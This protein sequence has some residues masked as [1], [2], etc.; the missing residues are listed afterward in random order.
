MKLECN[1]LFPFPM[2]SSCRQE[3]FLLLS[4][5][6]SPGLTTWW[7]H[8]NNRMCSENASW[9]NEWVSR[10][11][12]CCGRSEKSIL[13]LPLKLEKSSGRRECSSQTLKNEPSPSDREDHMYVQTHQN[14]TGERAN[15]WHWLV[16]TLWA[17]HVPCLAVTGDVAESLVGTSFWRFLHTML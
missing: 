8:S 6:V 14:V 16:K 3:L 11:R 17:E 4:G 7:V 13:N 1:Y 9:M 12:C 10:C 15:G 5:L 2:R